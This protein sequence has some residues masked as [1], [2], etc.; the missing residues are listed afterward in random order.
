MVRDTVSRQR[1]CTD[2]QFMRDARETTSKSATALSHVASVQFLTLF[3][4]EGNVIKLKIV[5]ARSNVRNG[6][7]VK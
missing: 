5:Q 3:L 7:Q 1:H 2:M 6:N 4:C